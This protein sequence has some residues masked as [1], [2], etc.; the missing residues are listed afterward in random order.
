MSPLWSPAQHSPLRWP[1][2]LL[3]MVNAAIHGYLA[4]M[5]LI[6]APYIGTLF[7]ALSAACIVLAGLL[8]FLD[9]VLVWAATG[10]MSL[11]ALVAFLVSRT[12]GLPQIR[13][14]IGNWTDPLGYPNMVVEILTITVAL[15]V[16]RSWRQPAPARASRSP[17]E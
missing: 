12:I 11:L 3:L 9:N 15:V 16:L 5:H 10:A 13:D 4:P 7:I 14:D 8:S 1:A 6:E 2:L 17:R